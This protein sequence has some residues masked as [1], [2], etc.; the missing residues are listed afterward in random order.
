[1]AHVQINPSGIAQESP[2]PRRLV[3]PAVMEIE[4]TLPLNPEHMVADLMREPGRRMVR[5]VLMDE[6]SVLG[7][8][9]ENA[10]QHDPLREKVLHVLRQQSAKFFNRERPVFRGSGMGPVQ[11]GTF[12]LFFNSGFTHMGKQ[13]RDIWRL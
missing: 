6:E 3:M 2:I 1:M 11:D 4:H 7:F 12:D 8:Q 5:T 13:T 10:V 9:S